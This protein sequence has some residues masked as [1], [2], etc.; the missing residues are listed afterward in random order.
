MKFWLSGDFNG[1]EAVPN[2]VLECVRVF[3]SSVF[4]LAVVRK[5]IQSSSGEAVWKIFRYC[6]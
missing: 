6:S 3:S 5:L 1:V 4:S 2:A